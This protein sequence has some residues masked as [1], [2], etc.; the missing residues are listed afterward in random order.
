[1]SNSIPTTVLTTSSSTTQPI[2]EDLWSFN[3]SNVNIIQHKLRLVK[4]DGNSF[5]AFSKYFFNPI[6]QTYQPT[7]KQ[8]F[9]PEQRWSELQKGLVG[10]YTFINDHRQTPESNNDG[11]PFRT[12]GSRA[13]GSDR[14]SGAGTSAT[15]RCTCCHRP[16]NTPTS[17]SAWRCPKCQ[18]P[19]NEHPIH[20]RGRGRPPK[21][22][23]GGKKQCTA[24]E[25]EDGPGNA[26]RS[27]GAT[28]VDEKAAAASTADAEQ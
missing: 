24:Q 23:A 21:E 27:V 2:Y 4:V 11:E 14:E 16:A 13:P 3:F 17:T 8:Y 10:L 9:I 19:A 20:K 25:E 6:S 22:A 15:E 7:K 5:I 26:E 18:R 28:E 12:T 1:M